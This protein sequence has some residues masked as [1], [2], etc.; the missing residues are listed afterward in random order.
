MA[1]VQETFAAMPARFRP[2]RA[3]GLNA[4]I[5]Y[6]ITGEGGGTC[7]VAIADGRCTLA[8]GPAPSPSLTI[9][10]AAQDWLDM[11]AGRLNGQVAFMSGRLRHKGDMSLLLRLAG[12][13]GL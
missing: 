10:M 5:Q 13:F 11:L 9:T 7:H 12:L 4:V 8:E 3:Q 2:E 6:E 1:T